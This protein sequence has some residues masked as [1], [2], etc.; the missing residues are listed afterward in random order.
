MNNP[1]NQT[2]YD[3]AMHDDRIRKHYAHAREKHPYFCDWIYPMFE[4]PRVLK[5]AKRDIDHHLAFC[6]ERI[7]EGSK[8]NLLNWNDLL[9]C[10]MW[11]AIEAL[12]NGDRPRAV[13]KLYAMASVILRTVDV[14]EGRQKL[15]KPETEGETK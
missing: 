1:T 13:E 6:R 9:D 15:G 12:A 2:E 14:L 3:F 4:A 10:K 11:E 5:K 8:L 7:D